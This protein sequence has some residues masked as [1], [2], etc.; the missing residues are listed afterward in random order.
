VRAIRGAVAKLSAGG[1]PTAP[2]YRFQR[3]LYRGGRPSRLA[4]VMN[5]IQ[6]IV[7]EPGL[8]MPERLVTMRVPGRRTGRMLSFPLV[9]ADYAGERYLVAMLGERSAWPKNVRAAGGRA[10]LRHGRIERVRLEEVPPAERAPIIRRYL[11]CAPG[12]R[13]HI[14]VDRRAPLEE[15]ERIAPQ[16]PVFRILPDVSG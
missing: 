5:R 11:D 1:R 8:I 15:F 2:L 12:A 14:P 16:I 10:T 6:V 3:W 7:Q 13:P 4:R 9:V